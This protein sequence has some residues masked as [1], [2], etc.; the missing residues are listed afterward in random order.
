MIVLNV[1]LCVCILSAKNS[2]HHNTIRYVRLEPTAINNI[3]D[4]ECDTYHDSSSST[5]D[6]DY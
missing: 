1:G 5:Y 2:H 4:T 6:N 3:Q